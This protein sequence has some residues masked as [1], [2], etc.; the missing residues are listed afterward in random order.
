MSE[1]KSAEETADLILNTVNDWSL[2][3]SDDL[4]LIICDYNR[5]SDEHISTTCLQAS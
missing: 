3:Q 4:T 1:A 2:S 5:N